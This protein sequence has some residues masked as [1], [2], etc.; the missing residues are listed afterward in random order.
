[1]RPVRAQRGDH[2]GGR[3]LRSRW[4]PND[5]LEDRRQSLDAAGRRKPGV[6]SGIKKREVPRGRSLVDDPFQQPLRRDEVRLCRGQ[7]RRR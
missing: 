7:E 2:I 1:M 4:V 3:H 5:T 6:I